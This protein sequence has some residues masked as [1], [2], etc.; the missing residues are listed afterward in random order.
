MAPPC[1]SVVNRWSISSGGHTEWGCCTPALGS[2][3]T[4]ST[5]G[6]EQVFSMAL[7]HLPSQVRLFRLPLSAVHLL[8]L[9]YFLTSFL[10]SAGDQWTLLFPPA[11]YAHF[12]LPLV[13]RNF[14][15][16]N[17]TSSDALPL[18][19][20]HSTSLSSS[21]T[22]QTSVTTMTLCSLSLFCPGIGERCDLL[23]L[24]CLTVPGVMEIMGMQ[25][26]GWK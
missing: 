22:L 9:I 2:A 25:G 17:A 7:L 4:G 12:C 15:A 8:S 1:I 10:T 3:N 23:L 5:Q 24:K 6:P 16:L 19:W 26:T 18:P 14:S 20:L 11:S 13:L 21:K